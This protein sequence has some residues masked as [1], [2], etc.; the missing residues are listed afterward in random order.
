VLLQRALLKEAI[1]DDV[2]IKFQYDSKR[3]LIGCHR[4][5]S[6]SLDCSDCCV[7]SSTIEMRMDERC[8]RGQVS[9][10]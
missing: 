2:K 6:E 9:R 1:L 4:Q 7:K 3:N 10:V 5:C 8:L